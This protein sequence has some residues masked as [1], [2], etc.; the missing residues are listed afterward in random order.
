MPAG[1]FYEITLGDGLAG[2]DLGNGH[3]ELEATGSSG[4]TLIAETVLTGSA[5]NIDFTSIA[6]TWRHLLL[7]VQAR[8][9]RAAQ[10][11]DTLA[12]RFNNDS[13]NNYDTQLLRG[14]NATALASNAAAATS[15]TLGLITGA[16]ASA[17]KSG[18]VTVWVPN[19]RGTAFEKQ[20]VS[21]NAD[22]ASTAA[23]DMFSQANACNWRST[24]A[25]TRVTIFSIN[26]ANLISGTV[27][28]LYGAAMA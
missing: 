11:G 4:L 9:D 7:V 16:G 1:R 21:Q 3:I 26:G 25:I 23:A 12:L 5:A 18:I 14:N 8:T 13:G 2:A 24:A 15:A 19:Y 6:A 27:A 17:G 20:L 28:S 10:A 22:F